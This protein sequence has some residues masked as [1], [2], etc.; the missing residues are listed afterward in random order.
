M[1]VYT[2]QTLLDRQAASG[3]PYLEFLRV[4]DLSLGLYARRSRARA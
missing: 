1:D 4:P 2:L 3:G